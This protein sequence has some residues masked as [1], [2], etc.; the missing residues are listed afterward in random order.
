[1]KFFAHITVLAT[2]IMASS[3]GASLIYNNVG[4]ASSTGLSSPVRNVARVAQEYVDSSYLA[5]ITVPTYINGIGFRI[6][7]NESSS[8]PN[9]WPTQ[10]LT[11]SQ[12]DITL[13]QASTATVAAH[14]LTSTTFTANWANPVVVRSGAMTI[15]AN[16][17]T[18]TNTGPGPAGSANFSFIIPFTTPY[19]YT[20]G[21]D[22]VVMIRQGGYSQAA[23]GTTYNFETYSAA[24]NGLSAQGGARVATTGVNATVSDSTTSQTDVLKFAFDVSPAPEPASFSLIAIGMGTLLSRRKSR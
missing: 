1:M 8:T 23:Q 22:L 12:Y 16:S 17:F 6:T 20:P 4:A 7:P 5:A 3:A 9:I 11:F 21:D 10:A 15:P 24:L 19:L 14:G 2:A 18:D 13:A